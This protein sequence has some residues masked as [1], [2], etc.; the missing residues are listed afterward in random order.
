MM[1]NKIKL[2][3]C[4][5]LFS[6]LLFSQGLIEVP[7][8]SNPVLIHKWDDIKNNKSVYKAPSIHDI[9][10]LKSRRFLDD[11]SKP[12]PLPDTSFWL[13]NTVYINHDYGIAPPT[14]GV[15]TFDGVNQYG[16][17][18]N[19]L[20]AP[21]S[22]GKADTLT[23][24]LI[25]MDSLSLA[26]SIYFSFYY[27]PQGR[28]NAPEPADSLIL[29]FKKT[30]TVADPVYD[31][32]HTRVYGPVQDTVLMQ[33]VYELHDSMHIDTTHIL[34]DSIVW[35]H[36]WSHKGYPLGFNDSTWKIV[37]IPFTDTSFI[38]NDFQ[39]RFTN[40]ATLS[41][42][43][44]HWNIDYV[45]LNHTRHFYD[46]IFSDV[47]F[48]YDP[49][50]LLKTY[51]AMPWRQ[52]DSTFMQI[53][54]NTLLRNNDT[55][56]ANESFKNFIYNPGGSTFYSSLTTSDN[57]NPY[58]T[59]HYY[60][61]TTDTI[62]KIPSPLTASSDYIF[63]ADLITGDINHNN[64]TLRRTQ[65]FG[66][67]YAYDDGT[68][69]EGFALNA[70]QTAELAEQFTLQKPDTLRCIDIYFDPLWTDESLYTFNFKVWADN[71]GQP[72]TELYSGPFLSPEYTHSWIGPNN[73]IRYQIPALY[74]T[75]QTFYIGY[76]QNTIQG[77]NIGVDKMTNSQ[78]QIFYNTT[79]T[80]YNS[81]YPG[82]LMMHPVFGTFQE[83][84][85]GV[86]NIAQNNIEFSIYPNPANDLLY[87]N[88]KSTN[89][90]EK[91]SYSVI[92]IYGR[93][94]INHPEPAEGQQ[95][96]DISALAEGV[97]FIRLTNGKTITTNKF[98]KI[99]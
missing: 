6:N 17:P 29:E 39:F 50:S 4:F 42:A 60:T 14:L 80:W 88:Y 40:W 19:F 30:Y 20:A 96:I 51:T 90:S 52:Y 21:G 66:N 9:I 87:V 94:I 92:D 98:I 11:F 26:D 37:M 1:I 61:Y 34:V 35:S 82:S 83:L 75:P 71:A 70:S 49:P 31:T 65:S 86:N 72:G 32:T 15:A 57:V 36:V 93:T 73:F 69:E 33:V 24:K 68:A 27:Q 63:E 48:V 25:S 44:D 22:S 76:Q 12:G 84:S 67:Y 62:P 53:T 77:L 23:S 38:A 13:T 54:I 89:S 64:D 97:Y 45:Y 46:T 81:P 74:L 85:S 10:H 55:V 18:Y 56:F 2:I 58:R 59:I 99:K 16:Y 43:G 28:G 7:L 41:G 8:N 78:Y 91:I 95:A 5:I 3:A 47:A 79:G